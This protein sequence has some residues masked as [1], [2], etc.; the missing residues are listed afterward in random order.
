[1]DTQDFNT[2]WAVILAAGRGTR[3]NSQTTN[4]VAMKIGGVPMLVRT[5]QNLHDSNIKNVCIVVGFAK[6]SVTSL[7]NNSVQFA[8][9]DEQL[10]TGH[11]AKVGVDSLP[12]TT[13]D[14]IIL[15]GDDS[16]I[17][18]PEVYKKLIEIHRR[19]Q[20]DLSFIT[21]TVDDP[22]GLGRIMRDE[23]GNVIGIVEE[24][25]AT[26]DQK[27]IKEINPACYI[28]SYSFFKKYIETVP[29]SPVTGE[30]YL[31]SLVEIAVKEKAKIATYTAT[32]LSWRGVN[33]PDELQ[34][35]EA[36]M[37]I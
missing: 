22:K 24:K 31:T 30:Y 2:I 23:Q 25:D 37:Q 3:M 35:A 32:G 1:M 8:Q 20:A 14:V 26:D 29:K 33:T 9:Q 10:G 7:F 13:K 19:E 17:Y 18:T 36:M 28:F 6:E 27:K 5:V 21:L 4:K 11:A 12:P 15:Y 16:Y 34:Q